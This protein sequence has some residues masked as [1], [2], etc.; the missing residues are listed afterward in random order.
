[1]CHGLESTM[2]FLSIYLILT[3]GTSGIT[4]AAL[5]DLADIKRISFW[6]QLADWQTQTEIRVAELKRRGTKGE[7]TFSTEWYRLVSIFTPSLA[8]LKRTKKQSKDLGDSRLK[9]GITS[10]LRNFY[11]LSFLTYFL[12]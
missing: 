8:K 6:K 3:C 1:M 5:F 2:G 4:L 12:Q 11:S 7:G 10:V 9:E